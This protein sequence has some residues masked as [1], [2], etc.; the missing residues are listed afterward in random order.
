[1]KITFSI[2]SLLIV[3][4]VTAL[5][6]RGWQLSRPLDHFELDVSGSM[7]AKLPQETVLRIVE[8][9]D[10]RRTVTCE[11]TISDLPARLPLSYSRRGCVVEFWS[12]GTYPEQKLFSVAVDRTLFDQFRVVKLKLD[13]PNPELNADVDFWA[14]QRWSPNLT[15]RMRYLDLPYWNSKTQRL[16]PIPEM[17]KLVVTDVTSGEIL[18]R[19]SLDHRD[20]DFNGY[21]AELAHKKRYNLRH[22][23]THEFSV[24]KSRRYNL[25]LF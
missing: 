1:M 7:A 2:A 19:C 24:K 15:R 13:K 16:E 20:C 10:Y 8:N 12:A 22:G 23:D 21:Y 9:P 18:D 14:S 11:F 6:I 25:R 17:P 5:G 4:T 3:T